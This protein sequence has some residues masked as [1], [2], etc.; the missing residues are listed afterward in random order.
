M[1]PVLFISL[2]FILLLLMA[3]G[4]GTGNPK[5]PTKPKDVEYQDGDIIIIRKR[6]GI[7]S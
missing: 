4:A 6:S 7:K 5:K 3:Q 2:P 1:S